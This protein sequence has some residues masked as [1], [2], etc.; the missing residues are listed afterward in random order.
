MFT[1]ID[2]IVS[3]N[4]SKH[5]WSLLFLKSLNFVCSFLP[6]FLSC[7]VTS[8]LQ[9]GNGLDSV[10]TGEVLGQM[11]LKALGHLMFLEFLE[12]A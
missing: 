9:K 7:L 1:S 10:Y 4:N 2:L 12:F 6:S 5:I 3:Y 8:E 11:S